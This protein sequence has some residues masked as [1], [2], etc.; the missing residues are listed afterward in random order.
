MEVHLQSP[1]EE[2]VGEEGKPLRDMRRGSHWDR[3]VGPGSYSHSLDRVHL[4]LPT[5]VGPD[6]L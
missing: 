6:G 2:G 4:P 5:V 1:G 3:E